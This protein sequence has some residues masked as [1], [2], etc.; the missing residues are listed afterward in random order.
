MKCNAQR[1]REKRT[2][3]A[4]ALADRRTA[5]AEL[6]Q[7][8]QEFNQLHIRHHG[9]PA[10]ALPPS[11]QG[12][13]TA[14]AEQGSA[15]PS[16]ERHGAAHGGHVR[17]P[18][19]RSIVYCCCTFVQHAVPVYR[20]WWPRPHSTNLINLARDPYRG[21][22]G[23]PYGQAS[24]VLRISFTQQAMGPAAAGHTSTLV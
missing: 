13:A 19:P 15:P 7:E 2:R 23:K 9:R 18:A 16:R 20:S 17:E 6:F 22:R 14:R 10:G 3:E 11:L 24:F 12:K 8:V 21:Y 4:R 5:D 1:E